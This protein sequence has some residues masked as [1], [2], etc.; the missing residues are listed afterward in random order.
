MVDFLLSLSA[1]SC[2]LKIE[3]ELRFK[4]K[5]LCQFIKPDEMLVRKEV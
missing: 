1:F 5:V 2:M 3:S 4:Y